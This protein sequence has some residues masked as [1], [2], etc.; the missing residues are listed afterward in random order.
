MD[1]AVAGGTDQLLAMGIPGIMIIALLWFA[2][3]LLKRND[4]LQ[5]KLVE[6][7][8]DSIKA[9]EANTKATELLRESM[10]PRIGGPSS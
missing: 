2:Y 7:V 8:T 1:K 5:D 9:S 10:R 3:T 6:I 4:A